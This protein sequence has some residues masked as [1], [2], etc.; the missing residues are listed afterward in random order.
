MESLS[1]RNENQKH[2]NVKKWHKRKKKIIIFLIGALI[3]LAVVLGLW[4]YYTKE[5]NAYTVVDSIER[6]DTVAT[7]YMTYNS[8]LMKYSRDGAVG[9]GTDLNME[10]AGSYNFTSPI[11]DTCNEYVAIADLGGNEILV[12][13]GNDSP[14]Q[15]D[16][17]YPINL[18]QVS[19]QGVV[20]VSMSNNNTD[21]VQIYDSNNKAELLVEFT[22]NVSEDGYP[23]DIALSEDG[24]KLVTTY[25]NVTHGTPTSKVTF[26]N[27]GEVGKN[28][29]N[30][31]VAAKTFEKEI[32][33]RVEFFGNNVVCAFGEQG[34]T[35]YSMKQLVE[36]I[37]S[38]QF[39]KSIKSVF[40]TNENFGFV[41]EPESSDSSCTVELY[42]LNGKCHMGE[43]INFAYNSVYMI[44]DEIIFL[45]NQ[46]CYILRTNGKLKFQCVFDS[47]ISY[48]LPMSGFNKYILV[49]ENSI[50]SIKIM[51]E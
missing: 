9:Y 40:V 38:K 2:E 30:N 23:V 19:T 24:T 31:I 7:N 42:N 47:P 14:T 29:S 44:N 26:Y 49:D 20:A 4:V 51:E 36:D 48:I 33:S 45:A 35:L 10:W 46:E 1:E 16:V 43:N 25:L 18:I 28:Y 5:Y 11:I 50:S 37:A 27:L 17:L 12:F 39:K 13:D 41:L 8:K 22:T 21:L 3:A 15:I 34:F 6:S 32:V